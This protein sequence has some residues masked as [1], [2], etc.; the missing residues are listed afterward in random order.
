MPTFLDEVINFVKPNK[1]QFLQ[2]I[3]E[4]ENKIPQANTEVQKSE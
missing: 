4:P 2:E 1:P 3:I